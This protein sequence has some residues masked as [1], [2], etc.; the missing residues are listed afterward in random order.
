MAN[1]IRRKQVDQVEFSGFIVEVGD[2]N[3]YPLDANPSGYLDQSALNSATGT[4]NSTINLV[5]GTLNTTILNTGVAANSYSDT[6][7]GT[8]STRLTSSGNYLSGQIISLSGY[9]NTV[10]G[11]LYNSITGASGV[12]NTKIDTA[13]G[14]LKS[15]TDTTSGLLYNQILAQSSATN[16]SNI[17]SGNNFNFSGTK[18]FISPITAQ[19]INISGS[20]TPT[21]I[22]I[23]ASSGAVSIAGN[24]GPFVTYYET[25]AN[26]SLWAVT[27]SAGLPM[28]ELFD[29]YTLI[30]GH[31]SR[32]S[33]TLSGISGYVLMQ[34]LPTQTQTGTLP[35]GTIFRSGNYLM[36]I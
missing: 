13:S 4:I 23:I 31:T 6:V 33:V 30:L 24:S 5:S 34:N 26:A 27:D 3:Y 29:D 16:V 28:I 12:L 25:G 18:N 1:L 32:P 20:T 14:Y 2:A 11:N 9:T 8:L 15:Y 7:S 36:I 10:S 35:S 17:A 22:S 21:S 19:K